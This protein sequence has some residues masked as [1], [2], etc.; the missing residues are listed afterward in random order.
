MPTFGSGALLTTWHCSAEPL[1]GTKSGP[2]SAS[3]SRER[4]PSS[5]IP[6]VGVPG[7]P[8]KCDDESVNL[9]LLLLLGLRHSVVV[10]AKTMRAIRM[11]PVD[12]VTNTDNWLLAA[13]KRSRKS[14]G[15]PEV[16]PTTA[17]TVPARV[18]Q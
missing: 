8:L 4:P 5:Q 14:E 16:M 18:K 1:Q 12:Q 17:S 3:S 10:A 2:G 9:Q 6:L 11:A 7:A 15:P 13:L